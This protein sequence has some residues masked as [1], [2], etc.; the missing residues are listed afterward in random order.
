MSALDPGQVVDD[1][2]ARVVVLDRDEER[3]PEPV[4]A[5]EVESGVRQRPRLTGDERAVVGTRPILARVLEAELVEH[6][7]RQ[8]RRER[9]GHGVGEAPLHGVGAAAPRVDVECAVL[10]FAPGVVVTDAEQVRRVQ[11]IVDLAQ[12]HAGI[13]GAVNRAVLRRAPDAG[14][15]VHDLRLDPVRVELLGLVE[16]LLVIG[17]E[18]E[19]LV[20]LERAAEGRSVLLLI[21]REF[22]SLRV[23]RRQA[24]RLEEEVRRAAG[25]VGPRLGDDVDEAGAAAAELRRGP[26]GHDDHLFDGV[27]VEGEGRPLAAALLAEERVVEVRAVHGDVV[28]DALLAVDADLVA[29]GP[30]H[31]GHARRQLHERQEVAP[32]VGQPGHGL[33]VDARG[34]L[35]ARRLDDRR[36]RRDGDLLLHRG[37]LQDDWDVRG[38]ADGQLDAL[39]GVGRKA[40]EHDGQS[41]RAQRQE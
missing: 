5:H 34:L 29:V 23:L 8:R 11:L 10:L 13:V 1:L 4:A 3:H 22:L 19:Q 32:V 18:E 21:E 20:F 40:R 27:L 39:L 15:V 6:A 28:V 12:E 25:R 26:V 16:L 41:I 38:L 31:D 14:E 30:L 33:L 7:A 2:E 9:P 37:Q 24:V 36:I 17:Q 35:G